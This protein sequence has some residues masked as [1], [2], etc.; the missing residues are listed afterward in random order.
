[1]KY[2]YTYVNAVMTFQSYQQDTAQ[3]RQEG[4]HKGW[5]LCADGELGSL[6]ES[7]QSLRRSWRRNIPDG[8]SVWSQKHK[9]R[10]Q[11]SAVTGQNGT[12]TNER[13]QQAYS[14][15]CSVLIQITRNDV[16]QTK[17]YQIPTTHE[18]GSQ[19]RICSIPKCIWLGL[20]LWSHRKTR[21]TT[22]L[23]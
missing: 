16:L 23:E 19:S 13:R 15:S 4:E 8:R 5:W 9:R 14:A 11:I 2:K 20:M 12:Y 21:T 7:H 3:Q 10:R 1:M 22:G 17:I 18:P 6:P